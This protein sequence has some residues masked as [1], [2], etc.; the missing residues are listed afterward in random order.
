MK[1]LMTDLEFR[2]LSIELAAQSNSNDIITDAVKIEIYLRKG[3]DNLIKSAQFKRD[4]ND[5]IKVSFPIS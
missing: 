4:L 5:S 1:D 2:K 3:A